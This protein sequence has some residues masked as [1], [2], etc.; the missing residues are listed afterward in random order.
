MDIVDAQLHMGRGKI[1]AALEAMDALGIESAVLDELWGM[2]PGAG[3]THY[4]P[5][6]VLPNGAWRTG[7]PTAHEAALIYPERFAFLV[8]IDRLDPQLESVMRVVGSTKGACAFRLQPVWTQDE[9]EAFVAGAY[10]GL[11]DIAQDIGLPICWFVP[12]FVEQLRP[13]IEKY[14]K[15]NFV[16]DHC[17]MGFTGV[18]TWRPAQETALANSPAYFERVLALAEFPNVALKWSH[19]QDRFGVPD[20]PYDGLR[21]HLRRAISAFGAERLIW[22][23]D[24]TVIANHGW[25]DM[26]YYLRDDLELSRGEKEWI[27]GR[28]ARRVF[29]WQAG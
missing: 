10:D 3:I 21:P 14:P 8:R 6:H 26:L 28:S 19:A 12:G 29:N 22:A 7:F 18:S 5:G 9:A 23:S 24:N 1:E 11:L 15:L 20:Y 4:D 2:Q 13:Y 16:I 25:G 17:G 27:L